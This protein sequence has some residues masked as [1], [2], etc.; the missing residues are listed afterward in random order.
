MEKITT[1]L[2]CQSCGSSNI[3]ST[4]EFCDT[5]QNTINVWMQK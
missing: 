1:S 5:K 4:L 3:R 2:A